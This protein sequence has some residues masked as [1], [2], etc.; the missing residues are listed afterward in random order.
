MKTKIKPLFDRVLIEPNEAEET[1]SSG[2]ILAPSAVTP[3]Q[4]A[5][6]IAVGDGKRDAKGEL[7]PLD[8]NV[9]D[10]V[11]FSQYSGTKISYDGKSYIL[12][13]VADLFAVVE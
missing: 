10:R 7:I 6:V 12:M 11:I 5:V 1:T 13:N 8:V 4:E 3:P 9:G 2:L